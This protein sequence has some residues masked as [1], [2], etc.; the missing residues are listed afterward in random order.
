MVA[1][2][3]VCC[4]AHESAL[5]EKSR[6]LQELQKQA[7]DHQQQHQDAPVS[8]PATGKRSADVAFES[9]IE[10]NGVFDWWRTSSYDRPNCVP[11]D[12]PRPE[13]APPPYQQPIDHARSIWTS[14]FTLP[15]RIITNTPHSNKRNWSETP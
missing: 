6:Y 11:L 2:R 4:N 5:T 9:E 15:S 10:L 13:E 1:E 7:K 3:L 12:T 14:P 8:T